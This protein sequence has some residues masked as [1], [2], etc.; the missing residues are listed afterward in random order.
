MK[1]GVQT[2]TNRCKWVCAGVGG[3][4]RA[5]GTQGAQQ[6]ANQ[7]EFMDVETSIWASYS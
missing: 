7:G 6:Q 1:Y 2:A 4:V 5:Q 3:Y